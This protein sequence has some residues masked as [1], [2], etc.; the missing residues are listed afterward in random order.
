[1]STKFLED[2]VNIPER[3]AVKYEAGQLT[4]E[5]SKGKVVKDISHIP[6]EIEVQKGNVVVRVPGRSRKAKA[7]LG[8]VVSIIR[9]AAEGV[10]KGYTY[11]LKVVSSHF[12]ISVKVAGSEV[13][14]SNFLGER[15]DRRAKIVGD[16]KVSV[17]GDE[18]IVSGVDKETVGQTAANI[19][20]ATRIG[21]KD[22]RKFLDG[23]YLAERAA[24]P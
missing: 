5:G 1:M 11:K 18:V 22:P 16:V 8:T 10:S 3:V 20:N 9:N 23:I 14:I 6:A 13:I 2:S 17:K 7:M 4:V 24:G 12:P 15:Y 19:E 21:R